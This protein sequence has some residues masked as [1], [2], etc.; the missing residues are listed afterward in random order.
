VTLGWRLPRIAWTTN[1]RYSRKPDS[2]K[3]IGTAV[4]SRD[5]HGAIGWAPNDSPV[6]NP[7]CVTMIE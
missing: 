6:S 1:G 3:K 2:M 5:S 4:S 7:T